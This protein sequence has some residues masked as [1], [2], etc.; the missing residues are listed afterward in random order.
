M[1]P[2]TAGHIGGSGVRTF[3]VRT[4]YSRSIEMGI[5]QYLTENTAV[6]A[7]HRRSSRCQPAG[8]TAAMIPLSPKGREADEVPV[9]RQNPH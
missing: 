7:T 3:R 2:H 5:A 6:E 1:R 9:E 8:Q 4:R